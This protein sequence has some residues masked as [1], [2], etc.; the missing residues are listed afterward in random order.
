MVGIMVACMPMVKPVIEHITHGR[1]V[2]WASRPA[3]KPSFSLTPKSNISWPR[4]SQRIYISAGGGDFDK[5]EGDGDLPLIE[6]D[7]RLRL[8]RSETEAL[9]GGG[10]WLSTDEGQIKISKDVVV[11]HRPIDMPQN[12]GKSWV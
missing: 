6:V 5:L 11:D 1:I 3:A 10:N 7:K 2:L 12:E 9:E 4:V 8:K